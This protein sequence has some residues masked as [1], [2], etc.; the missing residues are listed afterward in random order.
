MLDA[1]E[2]KAVGAGVEYGLCKKKAC[3]LNSLTSDTHTSYFS[4]FECIFLFYIYFEVFVNV[5]LLN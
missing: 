3:A 5:L 1:L 4:N 2:G